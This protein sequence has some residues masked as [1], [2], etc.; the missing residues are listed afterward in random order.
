M[1]ER[2]VIESLA[3]ATLAI[4]AGLPAT[5]DAAGYGSTAITYTAIGEVESFG[6]HG[7]TAAVTEF[8]PIDTAVVAKVKGAKNYGSKAVTLGSLP[9]N[10]GQD[11]LETASE[12]QAHYSIKITYPDTS[13][14]YMDVLVSKFTQLG[15]SV[16]DVHK[17]S[18]E[19][20]IC[21]KPVIVPQA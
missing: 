18:A 12:S 21:R 17:I 15:G 4:S 19:L 5:Y 14:H 1:A 10:A 11:I 2:T 13:I 6:D 7:V 20:T 9:S 16:N 8:T 3:G